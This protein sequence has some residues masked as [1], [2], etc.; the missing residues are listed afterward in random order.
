MYNLLSNALQ[1]RAPDQ[2]ARVHIS[3]HPAD[4]YLVLSL[5][6]NGLGLDAS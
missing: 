3:C 4:D 6:D 2:P 5:Q 1:Y